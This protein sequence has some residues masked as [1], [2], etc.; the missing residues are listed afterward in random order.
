MSNGE[1]VIVIPR[2][3]PI[4]AYTMGIIIRDAALTIEHFVQ[5]L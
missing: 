2:N 4:N 5:L 1:T 3:D